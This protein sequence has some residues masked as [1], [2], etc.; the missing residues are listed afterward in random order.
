M[1]RRQFEHGLAERGGDLAARDVI[2]RVAGIGEIRAGVAV[3]V[4]MA[5]VHPAPLAAEMLAHPVAQHAA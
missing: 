3:V 4:A 5:E 1:L 2:E